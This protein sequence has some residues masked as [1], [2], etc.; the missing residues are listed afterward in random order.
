VS[1]EDNGD[2]VQKAAARS[3]VAH[4]RPY[5]VYTFGIALCLEIA[6]VWSTDSNRD[7]PRRC[8]SRINLKPIDM[9]VL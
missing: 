6:A 5:G 8:F 1:G 3:L 4:N 2:M 7:V 9:Y